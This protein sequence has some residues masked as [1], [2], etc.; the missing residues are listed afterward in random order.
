M[1]TLV[2]PDSGQHESKP[3]ITGPQARSCDRIGI[4]GWALI[5]ETL[6]IA[7]AGVVPVEINYVALAHLFLRV[8]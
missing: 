6:A 3:G 5:T 4:P 8:N 2:G 1:R 7:R